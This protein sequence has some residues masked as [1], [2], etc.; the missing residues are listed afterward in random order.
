MNFPPINL[1]QN[2][3]VRLVDSRE[4][5]S[6]RLF[7]REQC[8]CDC[9]CSLVGASAQQVALSLPTAFYLELTS[10]CPNHCVGCGNIFIDRQQRRRD[11]P[12]M[13][14]EDWRAILDKIAPSATMV[15]L[16]GGEPTHS[17]HFYKIIDYLDEHGIPFVV[18]TSGLWPHPRKLLHTLRSREHFRGFLISLHGSSAGQHELFTQAAGSYR[19]ALQSIRE[20]AES[21]MD[22]SVSTILLRSN[23]GQLKEIAETGLAHGARNIIF[24]RHIGQAVPQLTLSEAEYIQAMAEVVSL[25]QLG[26]PVRIGN[27]MPQCFH[28]NPSTGCTAGL[29]FCTIDPC[30]NLRPCN[31]S[32]VIAGSLL[33][34]PL[35]ELWNGTALAGWR[36]M[37][38]A[39]CHSCS[40]Y[41]RCGGGCRVMY[42]TG[43][44]ALMKGPLQAVEPIGYSSQ[45]SLFRHSIPSPNYVQKREPFGNIILGKGLVIPIDQDV[46]TFLQATI[47]KKTLGEI[48]DS[49]GH[50]ALTFIANLHALGL[51]E[52]S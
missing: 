25:R 30:G 7:S 41:G 13:S 5:V 23:L 22:A 38:P 21:G 20:V 34:R 37:V 40:A 44:D 48:R 45:V 6:P 18:L 27:C 2:L 17:P 28:E 46:E 33:A 39:D 19:R 47:E 35:E 32:K 52:L 42:E 15:K 11:R 10:W 12:D 24:A 36:A 4:P 51:I 3:E 16:T 26:Y 29:T 50:P 8:D 31:H 1:L 9:A 43:R 14:W 49:Y